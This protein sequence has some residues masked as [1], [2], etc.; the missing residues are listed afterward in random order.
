MKRINGYVGLYS[1]TRQGQVYSLNKKQ[2][3]AGYLDNSGV[4]TVTL[5]K[6]GKPKTRGIHTLMA[7]TYIPNPELLKRVAHI[8]GNKMNNDISNLEWSTGAVSTR[9]GVNRKPVTQYSIE[10]KVIKVHS[11][12]KEASRATGVDHK[13]ISLCAS[14]T[15]GRSSAGGWK[16]TF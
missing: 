5:I 10:G 16:W 1:I 15:K 13:G 4:L 12:I 3:L 11:S 6:D 9:P 8:D 7:E 2:F 14:N